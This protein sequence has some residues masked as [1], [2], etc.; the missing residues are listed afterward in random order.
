MTQR[1]A[2]NN[3]TV[4]A[5][6]DDLQFRE[7]ARLLLNNSRTAAV[8]NICIAI[9]AALAV[10]ATGYG[11]LWLIIG[12]AVIRLFLHLWY[13]NISE[14]GDNL[15]AILFLSLILVTLQGATWGFASIVLYHSV[16]DFHRFYLIAI[17]CGMAG[18]AVLTLT[19]SIL[20]FACFTFP[21]VVPL[22]I[23]LLMQSDKTFQHAGFMGIVF[24]LAIFFLAKRISD[25]HQELLR[26]RS[27]LEATKDELARHKDQLEVLVEERTK[28]LA[29]SRESYRKLTEEINDAIFELDADGYI[30]YLSPAIRFITGYDPDQ[31]IG[32][33]FLDLVF[34]EDQSLVA[35]AF[36]R[37]LSGVLGPAEFRVLD[38][39]GVPHWV[40]TSSKSIIK[41]NKPIGLR[42][43]LTDIENEKREMIE[44]ANLL[45]RIYDNQKLEAIGTLAGGIA[46]DFNNILSVIIGFCELTK[47]SNADNQFI[48]DN[49]DKVLTASERARSLV[50]QILTFS[51][52]TTDERE[53][54]EPKVFIR[55][56]IE[57]L[58]GS[59]PKTI[60]IVKNISE[61]SAPIFADP[62]QFNQII[63][64]LC[65]NAY[66]A[67]KEN[68]GTLEI[69][70]DS[71]TVDSKTAHSDAD[72]QEGS[73]VRLQV[74]DNG[75]GIPE[76]T[77][78]RIFEP[79]YTTKPIGQGTGLGL[80]VIHGVVQS[81]GGTIT[82]ESKVA[83][84]TIFTIYLP[85]QDAEL[86]EP[87]D[88]PDVPL[89][90]GEHILLVDDDEILAY[91]GKELMASLR[92]TV[93]I[94]TS[95][96]D[97]L[98]KF[99]ADPFAFDAVISDQSMPEITGV[100]LAT[101]I[102]AIRPELPIIICSG[103]SDVLD[104][105]KAKQ[106]GIAAFLNK[107][108]SRDILARTLFEV[109]GKKTAIN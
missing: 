41:D 44:K 73:Y 39:E 20:A 71:V 106:M 28:E 81:M 87:L 10:P 51:K 7:G 13:K 75:H 5:A 69:S 65:T 1:P 56:S 6:V 63:F 46:H 50:R 8:V 78:P 61:E 27:I 109:L 60:K 105:E 11:W 25:A 98:N 77:L 23:T 76:A 103:Y 74:K 53:L 17:I 88:E 21:S 72:L 100:Q 49:M 64:N 26:S 33:H 85:R 22:V 37:V 54:I 68:G 4:I 59:I 70:L 82:V 35:A 18:G 67:M 62:A 83:Q 52:R 80:S 104:E 95:G 86:T 34:S 92:Y 108:V 12:V 24:L 30:T 89:G 42:G 47:T 79:F 84:G 36:S 93:T 45:R 94:A 101:K 14:R 16:S 43:I 90:D 15:R 97:G 31:T 99:L 66:H 40:R 107:P 9:L 38:S 102:M 57:L 3:G 91:L 29:D 58:A 55:E 19:P 96:K 2:R 32:H 48:A